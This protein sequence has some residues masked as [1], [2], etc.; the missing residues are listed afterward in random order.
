MLT[1]AGGGRGTPLDYHEL[2]RCTRV[3]G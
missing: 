1:L 2:E 3:G